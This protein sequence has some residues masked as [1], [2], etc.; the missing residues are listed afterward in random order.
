MGVEIQ[1]PSIP[2][3]NPDVNINAGLF[4]PPTATCIV[5]LTVGYAPTRKA[6]V[7]PTPIG[8]VT[9]ACRCI[10]IR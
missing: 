2:H 1:N 8:F 9:I 3:R 7:M 10:S 4:C 6:P 5:S